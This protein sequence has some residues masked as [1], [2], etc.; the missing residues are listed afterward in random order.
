MDI[1][2]LAPARLFELTLKADV[3][4]CTAG[5]AAGS[6][7]SCSSSPRSRSFWSLLGCSCTNIC[8]RLCSAATSC[9]WCCPACCPA[10]AA[11]VPGPTAA[12]MA[13]KAA[14]AS[15][16]VMSGSCSTSN[17]HCRHSRQGKQGPRQA[18]GFVRSARSS[19]QHSAAFHRCRCAVNGCC[20][21]MR[22]WHAQLASSQVHHAVLGQEY[23]H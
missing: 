8:L 18:D 16:S 23:H 21:C 2:V 11:A 19:P 10:A 3:N 4:C 1:H 14:A 15:P 9:C 17:S 7:A 22:L 20:C 12:S 13:W 6:P 5:S